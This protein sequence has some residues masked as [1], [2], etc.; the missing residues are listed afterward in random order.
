MRI[1]ERSTYKNICDFLTGKTDVIPFYNH[2]QR[3][4]GYGIFTEI[5]LKSGST[6]GTNYKDFI[7]YAEAEEFFEH[8]LA[9]TL[10]AK[11]AQFLKKVILGSEKAFI[12]IKRK[13]EMQIS[14]ISEAEKN[15]S[16]GLSMD[17]KQSSKLV[18]ANKKHIVND[19]AIISSILAI[20][21][22]FLILFIL[23]IQFQQNLDDL[24]NFDSNTPLDYQTLNLRGAAS[25]TNNGDPD[26]K[27]FQQQFK[28]GMSNYL[29]QEYSSAISE[30]QKVED[31]LPILRK[32]PGFVDTDEKQLKLYSALSFLSMAL[33]KKSELSEQEKKQSLLNAL[34][35]FKEMTWQNDTTK[36][37][38]ALTLALNNRVDKAKDLLND[39][40]SKSTMHRK[41]VVLEERL[42]Q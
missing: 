35:Q 30:W 8:Y 36:Y 18:I 34:D 26:Y 41:K 6:N 7:T 15:K 24:Y 38:F 4:P 28:V 40:N 13:I 16:T 21:A 12:K 33:S 20:A 27:L 1:S 11:E 32:K 42:N 25:N 17:A 29:A 22:I 5:K 3:E 14:A 37:Y 2:L 31:K 19:S 39:I 23:P 10:S 9:G